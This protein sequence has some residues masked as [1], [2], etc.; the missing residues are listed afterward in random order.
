MSYSL[1]FKKAALKEWRKL[2]GNLRT[3][4]KK[5]LEKRLQ[6]HYAPSSKL[7]GTDNRFKIKLR[8]A[9]YRLV[10]EVRESEIVVIVMAV[11]KRE[12]KAIYKTAVT[13]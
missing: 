3:Q 8:N 6:D 1:K 7:S 4:F 12:G 13:R 2:D 9:G 5:K 11:G 10:Y